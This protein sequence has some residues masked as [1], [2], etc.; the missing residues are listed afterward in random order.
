[1][2]ENFY[3][4]YTITMISFHATKSEICW[5]DVS[6]K[7]AFWESPLSAV[8][9]FY[10]YFF[11][12]TNLL[13]QTLIF[14]DEHLH[15]IFFTSIQALS[16]PLIF[17]TSK[18]PDVGNILLHFCLAAKKKSFSS[19]GFFKWQCVR[20]KEVTVAVSRKASLRTTTSDQSNKTAARRG[21]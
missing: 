14:Q 13:T 10:A 4:N 19:A 5:L 21:Y 9:E 6:P 17:V 20:V 11:E 16:A 12:E 1:M 7:S 3:Q 15:R 18:T 2:K 8:L